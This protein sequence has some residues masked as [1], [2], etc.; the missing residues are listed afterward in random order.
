MVTITPHI[1][2]HDLENNGDNHSTHSLT[3]PWEQWWQSLHTFADMTVRIMVTTPPHIRWHDLENNGD[4][5][6]IH[7]LTWPWEQWW[8]STHIRWHDLENNGDNHSTHSL[9]WPWEQW[10]QSLHT[11]ADMTLRIMVTIT[12]HIRWHDLEYNGDNLETLNVETDL[13]CEDWDICFSCDKPL[14][15]YYH[16]EFSMV[17]HVLRWFHFIKYP[18]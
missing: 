17:T 18:N 4:N 1:R 5:Y 10:W 14:A 8:Q 2:W 12:P 3:W 15:T 6:S 13:F 7:S 11:F 16:S 9:T